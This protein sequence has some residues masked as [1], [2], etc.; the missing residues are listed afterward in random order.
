VSRAV[1]IGRPASQALAGTSEAPPAKKDTGL[2]VSGS[3]ETLACTEMEIGAVW[4]IGP[5]NRRSCAVG[6][7][8]VTQGRTLRLQP[9]AITWVMGAT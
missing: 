1:A 3:L 8:A 5:V 6:T 4:L 9:F 7:S 2:N